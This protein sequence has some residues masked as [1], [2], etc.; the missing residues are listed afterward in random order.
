MTTNFSYDAVGQ[1]TQAG[2]QNYTYDV[3]GNPTGPGIVIGADNRLLENKRGRGPFSCTYAR[4]FMRVM[5]NQSFTV[6]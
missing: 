1:L 4:I 6:T 2:S 3:A 5:S